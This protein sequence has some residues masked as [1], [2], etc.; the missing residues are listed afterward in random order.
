M[1]GRLSVHTESSRRNGCKASNFVFLALAAACIFACGCSQGYS[2]PPTVPVRGRVVFADG[3]D[4]KALADRQCAV[5]FNS[6]DEPDVTAYGEIEEDGTFTPATVKERRSR[7]GAIAGT[8]QVRLHLDDG[9]EQFVAANFSRFETSG[10]VVKIP[11]D[12]EVILTLRR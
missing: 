8:H 11:S 2:G 7:P 12:D 10:L 3:G 9:C 6:L 1:M 4:V 5:V